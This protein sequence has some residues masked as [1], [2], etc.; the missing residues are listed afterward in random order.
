MMITYETI[1]RYCRKPFLL[2]EG[3]KKYQKYKV[4]RLANISCDACERRIEDD[5]R[6]YLFNRD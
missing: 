6:K 4:N 5:S 3:T 1:C 2:Q